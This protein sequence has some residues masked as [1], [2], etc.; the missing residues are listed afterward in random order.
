MK[1]INI[2]IKATLQQKVQNNWQEGIKYG[3]STPPIAI[4]A[5][6]STCLPLVRSLPD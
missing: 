6:L 2:S 1:L 5:Q 3:G 4:N